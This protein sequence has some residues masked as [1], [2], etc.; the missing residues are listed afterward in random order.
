MSQLPAVVDPRVLVNQDGQ[1]LLVRA[2]VAGHA[3]RARGEPYLAVDCYEGRCAT[4]VRGTTHQENTPT[5]ASIRGWGHAVCSCG[6]LS[7]HHSTGVARRRWHR[8]H[9]A[10]VLLGWPEPPGQPTPVSP[11]AVA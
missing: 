10:R 4:N 8:R 9:K 5:V 7:P 2:P 6:V 1:D 3:L 11:E